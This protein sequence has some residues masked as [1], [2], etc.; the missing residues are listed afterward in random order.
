MAEYLEI[1][2]QSIGAYLVPLGEIKIVA[3]T[4]IAILSILLFTKTWGVYTKW[5]AV[6]IFT[7]AFAIVYTLDPDVFSRSS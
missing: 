3:P 2:Q 4:V 7:T 5:L 1:S 6:V